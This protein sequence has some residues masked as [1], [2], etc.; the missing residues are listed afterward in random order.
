MVESS[1][2]T[3]KPNN[4]QDHEACYQHYS[5]FWTG[6]NWEKKEVMKETAFW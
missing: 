6:I 1:G 4:D 3:P 5:N 2:Y